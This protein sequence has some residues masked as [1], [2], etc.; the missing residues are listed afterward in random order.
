MSA[1]L[2]SRLFVIGTEKFSVRSWLCRSGRTRT[3]RRRRWGSGRTPG[4]ARWASS[5]TF[6]SCASSAPSSRAASAGARMHAQ[7]LAGDVRNNVLLVH[8]A[9]ACGAP[10][11]DCCSAASGYVFLRSAESTCVWRRVPH[12]RW[13]LL[14]AAHF[15]RSA[16]NC[17]SW[18]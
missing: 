5:G 15:R 2:P 18:E 1:S 9:H 8:V 12:T 17:S 10:C 4:R 11:T 14:R 13:G 7:R 6:R 3:S 16:K